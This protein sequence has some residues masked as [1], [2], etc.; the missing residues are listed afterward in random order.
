MPKLRTN[1]LTNY[2]G[3]AW[4]ALVNIAF[5]PV[6]VRLL[7]VEAFGLVGL[8]LSLQ[9][10]TLLL[11][12][13]MGGVLNRE[14]ARRSH[15]PSSTASVGTLVRTFEWIIW[16]VAACIAL[17]IGLSAPALAHHWL[18]VEHLPS[19]TV[20]RAIRLIGI[21]IAMLWPTS[22]YSNGLSGL[23]RQPTLNLVAASFATL[24]SAGVV[25]ILLYVSPGI[26]AFLCWNAIVNGMSS[27][28]VALV[29]W[30]H[31]P[32][33]PRPRFDPAELTSSGRFAG[34]LVAITALAVA[35]SQLDRLVL[36][37]RLPLVELGYYTVAISIVAGL[38]R[39]IQPMFNAIYPRFSRLVA[40][41]DDA[42]LRSL[43]HLG[44]QCLA[45]LVAATSCMLL[46]FAHDV[47]Y[48]WTGDAGIAA[49]GALPLSILVTGTALNGM[50]NLPYALQLANGWTRLSVFTN[51]VCLIV[52]TPFCIWAVDHFGLAGAAMLTLAFNLANFFINV[53]IMHS[54]LLRGE[55][56][57]FYLRDVLPAFMAAGAV[58]AISRAMLPTVTRNISSL[59]GLAVASAICLAAAAASMPLLREWARQ[60]YRRHG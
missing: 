36:S 56:G 6:Y 4:I 18:H 31:V 53:P 48:V 22:F 55:L 58:A 11:D 60:H 47:I 37:N 29:F 43:Y 9:T 20:N 24:R 44:N 7:G 50:L 49:R 3:Q 57:A 41:R 54:R 13:G 52:G 17:V 2:A 33:G 5:I 26:E 15:L 39:I 1:I 25:P 38:G 46:A 35:L 16:P 21:A 34:G 30:R 27:L 14:I 23:E 40:L 42:G 12:F 45:P 19:N 51:L 59:A 28:V 10:I 32:P 8:M